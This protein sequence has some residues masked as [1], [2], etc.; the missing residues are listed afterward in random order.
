MPGAT[1]DVDEPTAKWLMD[2]KAGKPLLPG[3]DVEDGHQTE[4]EDEFEGKGF[5]ALVELAESKDLD[6]PASIRSKKG[7]IDFIKEAMA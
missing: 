2:N 4:L 7:V 6:V 3:N 5:N 1:V